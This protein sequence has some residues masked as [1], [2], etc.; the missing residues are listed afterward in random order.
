M[1]AWWFEH[2]GGIKR[3]LFV[4]AFLGAAMW[5]TVRPRQALVLPAGRRWLLQGFF[6]VLGTV[7]SAL[8]FRVSAIVVASA[9]A[10]SPSGVLNRD[11]VPFAL[12]ALL[13][14]LFLDLVQYA[15]HYLRHAVPLLWRFHQVHH[16]DADL[17]FST[18]LRFHPGDMV[19]THGVYLLAVA[20][21]APPASVVFC[22]EACSVV[23]ALFS[24]ANIS[25]PPRVDRALRLVQVTPQL[26]EIHH[27]RHGADQRSN[28]G[29]VFSFWDRL[30]RTYRTSSASGESPRPFG[31][32]DVTN[33]DSLR[34]W[35][36]L[37]L[38]FSGPPPPR[39]ATPPS[40]GR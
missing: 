4:V 35:A 33:D 11:S 22:F 39:A 13:A 36:M 8:V 12:R 14:F 5:E 28:L 29:V 34:P 19:F 31:L 20:A 1:D 24:H 9:V 26:H 2:V 37:A 27:S 38:P 30:F 3:V 32:A 40:G 18:G 16:A 7:A 21:A 23:Q 6:L 15:D 25:L 10:D 17:D